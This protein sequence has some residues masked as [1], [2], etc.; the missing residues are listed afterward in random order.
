MYL[1][2]RFGR[3]VEIMDEE[4]AEVRIKSGR[5]RVASEHEIAQEFARRQQHS[6]EEGD[7]F[8]QT[9]RNS[10]DG[11][12]MS[13]D[14]LKFH[15]AQQG[16]RLIERFEDQKVGLL[17]N[18]PYSV[19]SMRN[20]V[21]LVY[22]MFESSKL[23]ED[24]PEL[25]KAADEV[26]V[27]SK[28]CHDVFAE[29]GVKTTVVPLG[30]NHNAFKYIDR[31]VPIENNEP[32]VFIHYDSFNLRKGFQEVFE[33]FRQEFNKSENVKLILKT[34]R[35]HTPIPV[36]KGEF[37][38]IE[39]IRG[40]VDESEL[41]SILGRAHCMVFPSR[42]EGF[43]VPPLEAMATGLPTIVP[44]AHGISEYFNSNYMLEV[45]APGRCPGLY[46]KFKGQDV[47]EM[48]ICDI[49]DLRRQ[50]RYAF[51]HQAEMKELGT[52]AAEYVK[53][54][55]YKQTAERLADVIRRWQDRD[56]IKRQD[57]K[58]LQVERV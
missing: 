23:P 33:A 20:D 26:M 37:P 1:V 50:M 10:A 48:V 57:S 3:V 41:V 2:N 58:F 46:T 38:N 24:W 17:Y 52:A 18:Q 44:N 35:N 14:H 43:G 39:V 11:Y 51:D 32:F 12:G 53:A 25:L 9:V 54:W 47:G 5:M 49:D 7:V 30:Y 15:L 22:T 56:V 42:G 27:P 34:I 6:G 13:R 16:I 19:L 36:V 55:T 4:D 31:A 29:S 28:W 40:V 8:Y 21:R 45:K